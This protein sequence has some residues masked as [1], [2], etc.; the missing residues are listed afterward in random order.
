MFEIGKQE[1]KRADVLAQS[2]RAAGI[3]TEVNFRKANP[4]NQMKRADALGA[5]FALV[6]GDQEIKSGV[7]K[8]K[9]LKTG[10]QHEVSLADLAT[11]VAKL[12][13]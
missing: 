4:G 8:L 13:G 11:Q 2:L 3:A 1:G 5:R 10:A 12:I 6:L 7:A 9:E